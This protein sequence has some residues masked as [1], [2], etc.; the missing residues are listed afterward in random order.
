M[1]FTISPYAHECYQPAGAGF[2]PARDCPAC[3]WVEERKRQLKRK[4]ASRRGGISGPI[5]TSVLP[6]M[7][8]R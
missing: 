5:V 7:A 3:R 1:K 4:Q 2:D 6:E 8:L